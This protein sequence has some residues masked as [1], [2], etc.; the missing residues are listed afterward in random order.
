M[1]HFE[2]LEKKL[3]ISI[4][5]KLLW[6]EALTH[7]SWIYFNHKYKNLKHNERLE[8]LGDAVLELIVSQVLYKKCPDK[9]EG[10]L[11]L[12]R[13]NL[14]NR[15]RLISIAKKLEIDKFILT[16][17]NLNGKGFNTVLGNALESII[18]AMYLD[19]GFDETFDFVNNNLL[20]DIDEKIKADTYKDPKSNL[21]E[22]LQEELGVLP[23]YKVLSEEG[24]AH[25]RKFKIG[26][27][28]NENFLAEG[29]GYSKQQAET[30]VALKVLE[31]KLWKNQNT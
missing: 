9:E 22:I 27:F 26:L 24:P 14:V 3:G 31:K 2:N 23:E 5:N 15:E 18:G 13:A 12:I 17:K 19:N 10:E 28:L 8:F 25:K 20:N 16:G 1:I 6:E 4:K 7:N 21:Q 30:N 11:T 29:D